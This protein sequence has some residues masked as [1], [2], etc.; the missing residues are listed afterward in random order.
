MVENFLIWLFNEIKLYY[1][2]VKF[3]LFFSSKVDYN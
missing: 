1:D 2:I 3:I